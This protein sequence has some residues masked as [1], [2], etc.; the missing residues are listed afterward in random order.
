MACWV[1][2]LGM[3]EDPGWNPGLSEAEGLAGRGIRREARLGDSHRA[4]WGVM[5]SPWYG[6]VR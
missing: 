3:W 4:R 2:L 6:D 1:V 5:V